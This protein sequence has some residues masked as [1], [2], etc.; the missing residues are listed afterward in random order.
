[1]SFEHELTALE[2]EAKAEAAARARGRLRLIG[3]QNRMLAYRAL[4]I[5][6]DGELK[7][8]AIDV[9]A[10]LA[11]V[12]RLGFADDASMT[13]AQLRDRAARRAI[14]LHLIS[15][16]DLNG[17]QLAKIRQQIRDNDHD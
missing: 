11:A 16:I 7:A 17:N 14:V 2:V 5:G 4:F 9:I 1:M 13:D 3:R 10:D 6:A 12:A 8:E 15:R